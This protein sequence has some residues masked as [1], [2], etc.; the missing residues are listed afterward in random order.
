MQEEGIR[1]AEKVN[2]VAKIMSTEHY[3]DIMMQVR[4]KLEQLERDSIHGTNT[5]PSYEYVR[6]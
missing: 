6:V 3:I 5:Q 2:D 4:E 1:K